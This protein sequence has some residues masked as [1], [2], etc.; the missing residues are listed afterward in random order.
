M[1]HGRDDDVIPWYEADKL[2]A[3]LPAG[4][5]HDRFITGLYGHTGAAS[6]GAGALLREGLTMLSV[7]RALVRAPLALAT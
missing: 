2:R 1:I 6:V 5:P 4:L 3:G 7:A